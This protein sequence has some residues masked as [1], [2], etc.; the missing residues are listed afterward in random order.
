MKFLITI[1]LISLSAYTFGQINEEDSSAQV[2]TYWNLDDGYDYTVSLQKI[3]LKGPDTTS[4]E[5][6]TYDV[7]ITVID[8]TEDFYLVEWYYYNYQSN[9]TNEVLKKMISLSDDLK[10]V[11]RIDEMGT[12]EGVENWEEVS[13]FMKKSIDEIKNE[14][15]SIPNVDKLFNQIEEMYTSKEGIEAKS[16]VDAHQFHSFHGA[17]YT[18]GEVLEVSTEVANMYYP[19]KPFD[20]Q[21][22]ISLDEI[23]IEDNNYIIRSSQVVDSKQLTKTTFDYLKSMAKTMGAP[24]PNLSDIGEL[25]NITTTAARIHG[26][27][28]PIYS[29]QTKTIELSDSK[30][31]EERII[32]MK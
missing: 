5:I 25:T 23:N 32:E 6:L 27:G 19:Q 12:I 24:E 26:S 20:C 17:K 8:S 29:I 16:I 15:E 18:L 9:S 10:V 22:I 2:I 28:W 14:L 11:I 13:K 7:D 31:I 3:K 1:I 30:T 21:L 4:N